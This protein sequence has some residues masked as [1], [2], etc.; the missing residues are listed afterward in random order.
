MSTNNKLIIIGEGEWLYFAYDAAIK[1]DLWINIEI[2]SLQKIGA[3]TYDIKEKI[4]EPLKEVDYFL[5]VDGDHFGTIRES[6]LTYLK[7]IGCTIV[8]LVKNEHKAY[9]KLNLNSLIH[10]SAI[11]GISNKGWGYNIFVGPN[12]YIA[13]NVSISKTVTLGANVN[14]LDGVDLMKNTTINRNV[15]VDTMCILKE[16]TGLQKSTLTKIGASQKS[17]YYI[18]DLFQ[19]EVVFNN[20]A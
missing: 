5:A 11:V 14:I 6:M 7:S 9:F 4:T 17:S 1:L 19:R 12:A 8:S 15:T 3:Y 13:S 10:P 2:I 16:Y 18:S 20:N